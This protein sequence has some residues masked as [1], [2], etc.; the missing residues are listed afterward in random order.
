[1]TKQK[2]EIAE[3]D[4]LIFAGFHPHECVLDMIKKP[5]NVVC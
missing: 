5:V 2:K 4:T 3:A 1:V